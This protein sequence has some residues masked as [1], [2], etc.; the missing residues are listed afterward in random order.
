MFC[1]TKKPPKK[2][3]SLGVLCMRTD[4]FFDVF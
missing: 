2:D 4:M 3:L 1:V